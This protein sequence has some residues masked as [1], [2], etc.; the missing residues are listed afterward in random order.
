[1]ALFSKFFGRTISDAAGFALGGAMRSPLE[2]PLAELTN[3]T[4]LTFTEKGISKPPDAQTLAEGVAQGQVKESDA[5][6]WAAWQGIGKDQFTALISIA[7]VGPALGYAYEAW[8]RGFLSDTEF[9][10]ALKRQGIE[11]QWFASLIKLKARLVDLPTLA[12]GIQRGLITSPFPLPYDPTPGQGKIPAY[13]VTNIDAA[14]EAQGLGYYGDE[15][16]LEVG[17]AG[18]PPG[19]E[20]LFRAR[21]RGAID[22]ADVT[23][24]LVEGRSRAEWLPAFEA[25]ARQV[26]TPHDAVENHLRGYSQASDMYAR[27][28]RH[29]MS[30]DDTNI[31]FQ[32]AGRPLVAHQITTGLAR[33]AAFHPEPGE[34]TDPYQAAVQESNVK[35]S[36]YDLWIANRYT[37]PSL[38]Q[39]NQLVKA[40]AITPD[41]AKDW[42]NKDGYAPEVQDALHAFWVQQAGS[43]GGTTATKPR[44][45]TYSQIHQA[46]RNNVFT[47]AQ[48]LTEL[49]SIGYPTAKAQTLLATWKQTVANTPTG[50]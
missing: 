13:P 34:L 2:P 27:T 24:G 11:Q 9:Q 46:W 43:A 40:G 49:E 8:R 30:Q 3:E 44:A 32:N 35:P 36:Y 6:T 22:D 33:G 5:R 16:Q 1:M 47:D 50:G 23:R 7:N 42:A 28:A 38:F 18:N 29:G 4:W 19:P 21:W 10:T 15:L 17:L 14:K 26:S 37:Y 41:V 48:A 12:N 25:D 45:Y 31:L 39:L 20:G